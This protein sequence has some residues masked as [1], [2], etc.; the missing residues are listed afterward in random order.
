MS[1]TGIPVNRPMG[2]TLVVGSPAYRGLPVQTLQGLGCTCAEFDD[3]YAAMIE[4]CR[5]PLVYRALVVSLASVY[6]EEL[7]IISAVKARFPHVEI[8]LAQ[9]DSRLAAL[10]DAM[11]FGADGLVSEEGLHRTAGEPAPRTTTNSAEAP[12]AKSHVLEDGGFEAAGMDE[13]EIDT[14]D[15]VLTADELRALLQEQPTLRQGD[16]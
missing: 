5:R 3:P 13:A 12:V 7:A 14:N 2:R 15:A 4:L 6:R 10:A 1:G 16:E 8:W 9:A 11:R